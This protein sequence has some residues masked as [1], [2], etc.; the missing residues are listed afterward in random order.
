[1]CDFCRIGVVKK[2][3]IKKRILHNER[4]KGI[5]RDIGNL[6]EKE[7]EYY[8]KQVTLG[9]F[10]SRNY[11][12]HEIN[13]DSNKILSIQEYSNKIRLYFKDVNNI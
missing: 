5:I 6:F 4:W 3:K 13:G 11:I 7:K 8:Y 10:S 1:M 2:E 12:K 9:Y